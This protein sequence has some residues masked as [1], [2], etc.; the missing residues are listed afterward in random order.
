MKNSEK[1]I[2]LD[3]ITTMKSINFVPKLDIGPFNLIDNEKKIERSIT[4]VVKKSH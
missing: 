4:Q 2:L 1:V 3:A